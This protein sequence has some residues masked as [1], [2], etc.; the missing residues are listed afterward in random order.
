MKTIRLEEIELSMDTNNWVS[1]YKN[2]KGEWVWRSKDDDSVNDMNWPGIVAPEWADR[3]VLHDNKW[4]WEGDGN[5]KIV[6]ND[7]LSDRENGYWYKTMIDFC[8]TTGESAGHGGYTGSDG[9][10]HITQMSIPI[11]KALEFA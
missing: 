2:N 6:V 7:L 9:V 8:K 1:V 4:Y 5:K 11:Q 3:P 10:E